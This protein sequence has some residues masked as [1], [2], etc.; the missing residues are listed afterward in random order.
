MIKISLNLKIFFSLALLIFLF[1]VLYGF[2]ES[3]GGGAAEVYTIPVSGEI[4]RGLAYFISRVV[5]EAESGSADA[6]ILI[7]DTPGGDFASTESI[8]RVLLNSSVP[9]YTYVKGH[10][11]SAGAFIAV[12]TRHIYMAPATV[13]G[14]AT[15]VSG[16]PGGPAEMGEAVE[17]KIT[18]GIRAIMRAAAE[19]NE[20]PLELVE[21]MVDRDVEIE[22]VIEKGKLLTLTNRQAEDA[23]LSAGTF[24]SLEALI[25][26]LFG[27]NTK[28]VSTEISW[29]E[30]LARILTSSGARSMLLMLGL[31]GLYMEARTP[32]I[33]IAGAAAGI[34]FVLFFF[35]HY[36]AGL[37]GWEELLLFL[38]GAVFL[39]LELFVI[40]GFGVAGVLGILLILASIVMAMV[41]LPQAPGIPWWSGAQ[42]EQAFRTL[43]TALAGSIAAAAIFFR[44]ILPR[45]PMWNIISLGA[46]EQKAEGFQV[47]SRLEYLG[48]SGEARTML[49]PSGKVEV[50][51]EVLDA[52]TEGELIKKGEKIRVDRVEGNRIVVVREDERGAERK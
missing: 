14:A 35:G 50:L 13:I 43:G 34:C 41:G 17:Q 2:S 4:E 42:F 32:G 37:A 8:M 20:H 49:R 22:G 24:E 36:A 9:T 52:V 33:G 38:A 11:F 18:S 6:I 46:S 39:T 19:E 12:S 23:G 21:A 7:M 30:N 40:P 15:P 44:F 3:R 31:L 10:A 27:E 47:P 25:E 16:G 48:K 1:P 45:T 5:K 29:A 26:H 28:V 51:G